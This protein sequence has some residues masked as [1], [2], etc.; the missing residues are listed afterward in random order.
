MMND[1][2]YN[3]GSVY[4]ENVINTK[5][6]KLKNTLCDKYLI[7]ISSL[8]LNINI[9]CSYEDDNIVINNLDSLASHIEWYG[10]ERVS[11][12]INSITFFNSL[13]DTKYKVYLIDNFCRQDIQKCEVFDQLFT[14][15]VKKV[16][17]NNTK[18]E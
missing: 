9:L 6:N 2:M 4:S 7:N 17:C 12:N 15:T 13:Y 5:N 14:F 11:T 8:T 10:F 18:I 3:N 16:L 1:F